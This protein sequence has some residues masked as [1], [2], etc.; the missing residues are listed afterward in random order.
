MV[1]QTREQSHAELFSN[2]KNKWGFPE[3]RVPPNHPFFNLF[4]W[5]VPSIFHPFGGSPMAMEAHQSTSRR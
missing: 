5:D 3:I 1:K 2:V 4:S